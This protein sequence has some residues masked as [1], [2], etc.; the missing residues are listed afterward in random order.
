MFKQFEVPKVADPTD[1]LKDI[2]LKLRG[3]VSVRGKQWDATRAVTCPHNIRTRV[4]D[5]PRA[6]SIT[7]Q[8]AEISA[9]FAQ[10]NLGELEALYGR[11]R[12]RCDRNCA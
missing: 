3:C 2:D 11:M 7:C 1:L 6:Y 10:M 4:L 12:V 9:F 8:T 5:L